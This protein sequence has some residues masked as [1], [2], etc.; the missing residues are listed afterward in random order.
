MHTD[1]YKRKFYKPNFLNLLIP[2]KT[3]QSWTES[4]APSDSLWRWETL[5]GW[6]SITSMEMHGCGTWHLRQNKT[7]T[8]PSEQFFRA[9]WELSPCVQSSVI[10]PIKLKLK[11]LMLCNFFLPIDKLKLKPWVKMIQ[12]SPAKG[13]GYE[14]RPQMLFKIEFTI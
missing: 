13:V 3:L 5:Y 1:A 12:T 10:H 7:S 14:L 9:I 4:S 2:R 11:A 8:D 6:L